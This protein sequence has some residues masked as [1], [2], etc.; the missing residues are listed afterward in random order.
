M[1]LADDL[2]LPRF[3]ERRAEY[4]GEWWGDAKIG[5]MLGVDR[6]SPEG[7]AAVHWLGV[8]RRVVAGVVEFAADDVREQLAA[9]TEVGIVRVI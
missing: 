8:R 6:A 3:F 5:E 2:K 9:L 7:K 4:A 1:H